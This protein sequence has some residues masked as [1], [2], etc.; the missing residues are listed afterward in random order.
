MNNDNIKAFL[1]QLN[2]D[3]PK[4]FTTEI[5]Q[6][7][8]LIADD[9]LCHQELVGKAPVAFDSADNVHYAKKSATLKAKI[10]YAGDNSL[11]QLAIPDEPFP[12]TR[13]G[14]L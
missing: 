11:E 5:D 3:V 13:N 9:V 1:V 10:S 2:A 8:E 7:L 4:N 12:I 14:G 6:V